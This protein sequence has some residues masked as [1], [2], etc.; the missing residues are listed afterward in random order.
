MDIQRP[1]GKSVS[2]YEAELLAANEQV[3]KHSLELVRLKQALEVANTQQESLL[4][5]ISHEVKG[6]LS[7]SEAGFAAIVEGDYGAVSEKLSMM[8]R[9]ALSDTRKGVETATDILSAANLQKGTVA[10][11]KAEF[12]LGEA[13]RSSVDELKKA[14]DEK[15]VSMECIIDKGAGQMMIL[16][17]QHKLRDNVIRNVIDNSIRYTPSGHIRIKLTRVGAILR[18]TVEDTGVGI[19]AEDMQNLFKEGGRGKESVKVNVH[20]TGYGLFIAKSIVEAHGGKIWA[21]SDGKGK[22]SRFIVELP[23]V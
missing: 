7:K 23:A 13:V 22:G 8:A 10:Y 4:H 19:S 18:L 1:Q 3:Y 21:E 12:D 17:D 16:G 11:K 6:Y 9:D 14:A 5:F 15:G 20:S 2:D